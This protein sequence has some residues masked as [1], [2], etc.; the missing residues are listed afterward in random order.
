MRSIGNN[1]SV[2]IFRDLAVIQ[3]DYCGIDCDH[4]SVGDITSVLT[5]LAFK[6]LRNSDN[7]FL[8]FMETISPDFSWKIGYIHKS[9]PPIFGHLI[10]G[11]SLPEYN[12]WEAVARACLSVLSMVKVMNTDTGEYYFNL[13]EPDYTILPKGIN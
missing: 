9:I 6:E 10:E 7:L 5:G 13:G 8:N 3:G 2:S 11:K 12:Y 4:L 1:R